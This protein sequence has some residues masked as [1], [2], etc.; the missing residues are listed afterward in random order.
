MAVALL[1]VIALLS[2]LFMHFHRS[3]QIT[4]APEP[5][6]VQREYGSVKKDHFNIE[7]VSLINLI[8]TPEKYN[9]K[10]VRVIGVARFEFEGDALFLSKSDY[11][12]KVVTKNAVWLS[13]DPGALK[14]DEST[15]AKEFNGLHVVVE[16]IYDMNNHGHMSLFSGAITNVSRIT[17][18]M[19]R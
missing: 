17:T 5:I 11:D 12:Y 9:G 7:Y 2:W 10:W 8:A 16:G 13:I 15:L 19:R 6:K 4:A 1:A 18:W 14:V 3:N